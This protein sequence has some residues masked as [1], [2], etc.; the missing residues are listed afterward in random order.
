MSRIISL[1]VPLA[2]TFAFLAFAPLAAA[3]GADTPELAVIAEQGI[4]VD[5]AVVVAIG[6]G[7]IIAFVAVALIILSE[8]ISLVRNP[9]VRSGR[10]P[11]RR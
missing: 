3:A 8:M 10:R 2:A 4:P 7:A 1:V 11:I 6:A 5:G 9:I